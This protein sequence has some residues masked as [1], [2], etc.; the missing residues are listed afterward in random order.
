MG[1]IL[2]RFSKDLVDYGQYAALKE[3]ILSCPR[4]LVVLTGDAHFGRVAN[5]LPDSDGVTKL[6]EVVSSPMRHVTGAANSGYKPALRLGSEQM[7]SANPFGR[8]HR[9]HFA[10]VRF[11]QE[12]GEVMNMSVSYWP[13]A[14]SEGEITRDHATTFAFKLA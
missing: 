13:I 1:G 2:S 7:A 10:T 3:S 8:E 6:V 14:R 4:S 11:S 5:T 12:D 9:D